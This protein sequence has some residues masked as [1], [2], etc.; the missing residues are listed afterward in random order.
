VRD[1]IWC[2]RSNDAQPI[3][4]FLEG[5]Y[6]SPSVN[7]F[8]D[9]YQ[10]FL[11]I[12]GGIGITPMQSLVNTL[13]SHPHRDYIRLLLSSCTLWHPWQLSLLQAKKEEGLLQ[14]FDPMDTGIWHL[15][16]GNGTFHVE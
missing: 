15:E 8:S 6:G 1:A 12:A 11:L 3:K 13:V 9:K 16:A 7:I 2:C 14:L 5:P 4:F 10:M